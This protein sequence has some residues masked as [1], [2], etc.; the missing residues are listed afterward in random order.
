MQPTETIIDN[1]EFCLSPP[2]CR[3]ARFSSVIPV[4]NPQKQAEGSPNLPFGMGFCAV[5]LRVSTLTQR[6]KGINLHARA[7]FL[8]EVVLPPKG[9]CHAL[10]VGRGEKSDS[11]GEVAFVSPTFRLPGGHFLLETGCFRYRP[12]NVVHPRRALRPSGKRTHLPLPMRPRL[13]LRL[14]KTRSRPRQGPGGAVGHPSPAHWMSKV[15]V[16]VVVF[17]C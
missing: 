16:R 12:D 5:A 8:A 11:R 4:V 15:T 6:S 7:P 1:T 13:R 10:V 9:S 2:L 3:G 17:H 14:G